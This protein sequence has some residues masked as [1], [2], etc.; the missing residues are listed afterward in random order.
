MGG[1]RTCSFGHPLCWQPAFIVR[2]IKYVH[3]EVV[4]R[5]L[6]VLDA[7]FTQQVRQLLPR[8][9]PPHPAAAAHL[10]GSGAAAVLLVWA[11]FALY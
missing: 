7:P 5:W 6:G 4:Y 1:P 3:A 2:I 8:K 11:E 10:Q 9:K